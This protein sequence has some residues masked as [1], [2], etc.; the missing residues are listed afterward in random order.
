[1]NN[2]LKQTSGG[3][4]FEFCGVEVLEHLLFGGVGSGAGDEELS[5]MLS[6]VKEKFSA[7]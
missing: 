3:G 6:Q 7:L 2:S 4:I 1:M 5:N